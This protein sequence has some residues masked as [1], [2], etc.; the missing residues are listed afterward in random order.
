MSKELEHQEKIIDYYN[1]TQLFYELFWHG[2]KALGL[3]YGFWVDGVS[4]RENAIIKENEVLADLVGVKAGDLVLDAGCGIGGS[5]LWLVKEKEAEVVGLNLVQNQL[6]TGQELAKKRNL[7][8]KLEFT[9][10]DYQQL[11]FRNGVFDLFWSLESVEHTGDIVAFAREAFRVLKSGGK[12]IVAGTFQ[13]GGKLSDREKAQLKVGF[14]TA[15]AFL[16]W[17]TARRLT[18]VME[19]EGFSDVQNLDRTEWVMESSRQMAKMCRWGLPTAKALSALHLVSPILVTNNQWG[20]YQEGLFK[21]GATS[22]NI[23]LATKPV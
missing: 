17:G 18:Q 22:Y 3:H 7:S 4:N 19:N 23:V 14:K 21:S 6:V 8:Q 5:G 9:R 20:I 16:D 2:R 10:G 15:G 1:T 12:A 11:P 13:G